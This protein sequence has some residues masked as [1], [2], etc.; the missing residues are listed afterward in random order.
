MRPTYAFGRAFWTCAA[1]TLLSAIVS[2]SFSLL[3][4]HMAVSLE[5]AMYAASRSVALPSA[6]VYAMARRS[7]EG[8]AALALV[9]SL[10]QLFDGII[11]FRLH[12]LGRAYG[13]IAFAMINFGLLLWMNRSSPKV[14][15]L[16]TSR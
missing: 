15:P 2:M 14:A 11:G 4:L 16:P 1:F 6:V 5:Y 9:M 8:I 10:V 3:A 13:P 12:D 7:N